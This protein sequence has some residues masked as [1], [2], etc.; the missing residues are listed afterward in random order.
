MA[1]SRFFFHLLR[2]RA[3]EKRIVRWPKQSLYHH[4]PHNSIRSI[5]WPCSC[6]YINYDRWGAVVLKLRSLNGSCIDFVAVFVVLYSSINEMK[7]AFYLFYLVLSWEHFPWEVESD[8]IYI[9]QIEGKRK[10]SRWRNWYMVSYDIVPST[11][12]VKWLLLPTGPAN[13]RQDSSHLHWV[14]NNS[15]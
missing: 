7:E 4:R 2:Q 14:S 11:I 13:G 1:H 6:K 15:F 9:I 3:E 10:Q 12:S 8:D 5:Q